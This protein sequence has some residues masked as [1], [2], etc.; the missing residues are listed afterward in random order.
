MSDCGKKLFSEDAES[1]GGL[2]FAKAIVNPSPPESS[3][4]AFTTGSMPLATESAT[5]LRVYTRIV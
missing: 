2:Q 4:E 3:L 1:S 5:M